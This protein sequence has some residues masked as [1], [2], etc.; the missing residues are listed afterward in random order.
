MRD[1][2]R[3]PRPSAGP[4]ATRPARPENNPERTARA[5]GPRPKAPSRR[6]G[7][8]WQPPCQVSARRP[9]D[10]RERSELSEVS[11]GRLIGRS[12]PAKGFV[13]WPG[14]VR[15]RSQEPARAGCSK[16]RD[17]RSRQK[18]CRLGAVLLPPYTPEAARLLTAIY[19]NHRRRLDPGVRD[20]TKWETGGSM[21]DRQKDK[22]HPE[23]SLDLLD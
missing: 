10:P 1:S 2:A 19:K 11:R 22:T 21:T 18:I 6:G 9:R 13:S 15:G 16:P 12:G 14:C 3:R 7:F 5:P 20:V 4:R 17:E 8:S 23:S